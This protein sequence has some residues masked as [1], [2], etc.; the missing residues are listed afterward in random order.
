SPEG[1]AAILWKTNEK[2]AQASEA[3]AITADRLQALGVVEHVVDEG[4]G[5]YL[6][7][8]QVMQRLHGVLR[9]SLDELQS[10]E[11]EER[12]QQRYQRLMR[13]GSSQL[14]GSSSSS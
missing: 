1:C 12:C 6:Q 3:M 14:Q 4:E 7:P 10:I 9:S 2:A 5:A 8:M 13:F 11:S